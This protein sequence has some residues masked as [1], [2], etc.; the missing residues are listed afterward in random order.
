MEQRNVKTAILDIGYFEAG[1][2]GDPVAILM[3]GFPYDA[4]ACVEAGDMLAAEGWHVFAPWLRGYGP[5]RFIS[6]ETIRSGE[7]AALAAD[8][9][10]FMDALGI[11]RATVAGYDWGGRASCCAS[12]LWPE[13]IAGLIT[14]NGYNLF[15]L[16]KLMNPAPPEV[17]QLFWYCFYFHSERGRAG[18]TRYRRELTRYLWKDWSPGWK[19][20]DAGRSVFLGMVGSF[21]C[22]ERINLLHGKSEGRER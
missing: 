3:H 14:A 4:L 1:R 11:E 13:R 19:F 8:L 21:R 7:Q 9:L 20:S 12:A 18:L 6:P 17:E 2:A 10:A 15:H 5:T 16:G 22:G